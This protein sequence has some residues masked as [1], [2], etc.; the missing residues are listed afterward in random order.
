M[1]D[2]KDKYD[3]ECFKNAKS[4]STILNSDWREEWQYVDDVMTAIVTRDDLKIVDLQELARV[5][6]PNSL[7][8]PCGREEFTPQTQSN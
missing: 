4:M 5:T 6:S 1:A 8:R 2:L 3:N 7:L